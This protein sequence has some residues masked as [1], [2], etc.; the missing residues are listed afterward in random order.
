MVV[1]EHR[2]SVH[3]LNRA[4]SQGLKRIHRT[5][6]QRNEYSLRRTHM[7]K[8]WCFDAVHEKLPTE[9]KAQEIVMWWVKYDD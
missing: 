8:D 9:V 3:T 6:E 2:C 7:S 4:G 5:T 1:A